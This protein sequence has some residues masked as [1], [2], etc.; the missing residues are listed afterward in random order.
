MPAQRVLWAQGGQRPLHLPAYD[1]WDGLSLEYRLVWPLH[2]L[3]TPAVMG[4]YAALSCFLLCLKRACA[5][6]DEAWAALR[7]FGRVRIPDS[8]PDPGGRRALWLLRHRMAHLLGNLQVYMQVLPLFI[9]FC[10]S[11]HNADRAT[12]LLRKVGAAQQAFWALAMSG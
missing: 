10:F 12:G 5:E 11:S 8:G 3:L 7:G 2:L 9:T 6:L 1:A 4:Q